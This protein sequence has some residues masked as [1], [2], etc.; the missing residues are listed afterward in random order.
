MHKRIL[1]LEKVGHNR[2]IFFIFYSPPSSCNS[3]E[4]HM[5]ISCLGQVVSSQM[6]DRT[7]NK[8]GNH[9]NESIKSAIF[10]VHMK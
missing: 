7:V 5:F 2:V 3:T 4:S 6:T 8:C 1:A 9:V 10:P